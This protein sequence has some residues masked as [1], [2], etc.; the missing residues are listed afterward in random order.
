MKKI[1]A[2]LVLGLLWCNT[3]FATPL[4]YEDYRKFKDETTLD[5][6]IDG[7]LSGARWTNAAS[8]ILN[9]ENKKFQRLFC[10]PA[11]VVIDLAN[12]KTIIERSAQKELKEKSESE[13]DNVTII[14]LLLLGLEDTFPCK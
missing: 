2:I 5:I 13:V 7:L 8:F 11:D 1:L 3:V 10:P 6:Y 14:G 12:A 9:S 4:L